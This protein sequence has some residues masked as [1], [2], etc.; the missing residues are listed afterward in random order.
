[1]KYYWERT[2]AEQEIMRAAYDW[3]IAAIA[4][5]SWERNPY[6]TEIKAMGLWDALNDAVEMAF[7]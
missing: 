6:T 7:R 4:A 5:G 3:E 2:E 1:M